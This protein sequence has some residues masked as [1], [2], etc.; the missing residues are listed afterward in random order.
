MKKLLSLLLVCWL[1]CFAWCNSSTTPDTSTPKY[2]VPQ[3]SLNYSWVFVSV[4][5]WPDASR[6]YSVGDDE[7]VLRWSSND[8][9]INL[10]VPKDLYS[11]FFDSE[12]DYTPWNQI[13]LD[14]DI[15]EMSSSF[16]YRT[17]KA[18]DLKKMEVTRYPDGEDL[19]SIFELYWACNEDSDCD[20]IWWISPLECVMWIN[21]DLKETWL[22]VLYWYNERLWDNI[23]EYEY[24]CPAPKGVACEFN[25][26]IPIFWV[27]WE[28]YSYDG[29]WI[30]LESD[31]LYY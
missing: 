8:V 1:I 21:K 12:T 14:G 20:L 26:C 30:V 29:E 5:V 7:L 16:G 24:Q 10:R 2:E 22:K 18:I 9:V 4:W 23:E 28:D 19:K 3:K 31:V 27:E 25:S 13:E 15:L 6:D 11:K 17:F